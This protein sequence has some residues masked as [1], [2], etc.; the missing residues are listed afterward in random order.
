MDETSAITLAISKIASEVIG[1]LG[2]VMDI[3]QM[4]QKCGKSGAIQLLLFT[5]MFTMMA[6][7]FVGLIFMFTGLVWVAALIGIIL[8]ASILNIM[9]ELIKSSPSCSQ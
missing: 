2:D 9:K 3:L 1:L 7:L 5:L 8:V 4:Y 6:T